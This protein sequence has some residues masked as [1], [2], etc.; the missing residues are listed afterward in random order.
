MR[1]MRNMNK[2][3]VGKP[4]RKGPF[5]RPSHRWEDNIN[6]DLNE[7]GWKGVDWIHVAQDRGHWWVLVNM[8]VNLWVP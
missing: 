8:V 7:I 1:E 2:I 6:M 3:L 4:E 5:R